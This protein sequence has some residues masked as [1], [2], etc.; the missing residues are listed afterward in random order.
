M[1]LRNE[2]AAPSSDSLAVIIAFNSFT[3]EAS[4]DGDDLVLE[5]L[6]SHRVVGPISRQFLEETRF[7]MA[8]DALLMAVAEDKSLGDPGREADWGTEAARRFVARLQNHPAARTHAARRWVRK[9]YRLGKAR[10]GRNGLILI[11]HDP[12]DPEVAE[13]M[14][15]LHSPEW[16]RDAVAD[17]VRHP[18]L[19]RNVA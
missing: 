14:A 15:E 3:S 2:L 16:L 11:A 5:W 1:Q 13:H 4:R 19:E 18:D 9:W 8:Q 7:D 12:R 6:R 10:S 17:L